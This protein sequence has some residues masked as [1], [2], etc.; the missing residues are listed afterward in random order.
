MTVCSK[1]KR[2]FQL[3]R[4]NSDH[5]VKR[6]SL[7]V[8]FR[9][10]DMQSNKNVNLYDSQLKVREGQELPRPARVRGGESVPVLEEPAAPL[11]QADPARRRER[12]DVRLEVGQK[13]ERRR[14]RQ[15]RGGGG[16]GGRERQR[17][18][19]TPLHVLPIVALQGREE[20]CPSDGGISSCRGPD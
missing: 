14:S 20:E 2:D 10:R 5:S 19:A 6:K 1:D 17:A 13:P 9:L 7:S 15:S 18:H 11:L 16:G 3:S 12:E 4:A 8:H